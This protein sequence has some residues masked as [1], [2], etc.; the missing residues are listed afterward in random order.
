ME[1]ERLEKLIAKAK[2]N[3][4]A[5]EKGGYKKTV[6]HLA[7]RRFEDELA[8]MDSKPSRKAQAK[9]EEPEEEQE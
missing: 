4:A 7:L 5:M 1:R 9:A 3:V 6:H 8:K 2:R